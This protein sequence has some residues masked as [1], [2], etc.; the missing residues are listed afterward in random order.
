MLVNFSLRA[1]SFEAPVAVVV[2]GPGCCFLSGLLQTG[3]AWSSYFRSYS[4]EFYLGFI[5]RYFAIW[6]KLNQLTD[7]LTTDIEQILGPLTWTEN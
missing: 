6:N 5:E 7:L 3:A 4:S 2:T 1:S